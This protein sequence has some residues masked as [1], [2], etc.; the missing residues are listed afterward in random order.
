M[1]VT[2]APCGAYVVGLGS[3]LTLTR[4]QVVRAVRH[5]LVARGLRRYDATATEDAPADQLIG[6]SASLLGVRNDDGLRVEDAVLGVLLAVAEANADFAL[7][8]ARRRDAGA[9]LGRVRITAVELIERY[10]DRAVAAGAAVRTAAAVAGL[11]ASFQDLGHT[12]VERSA[13]ALPAANALLEPDNGWR[14]FLITEQRSGPPDGAPNSVM[15]IDIALIG[16]DARADRVIHRVDRLSI[17][18]LLARI[19]GNR[20]NTPALVALRNRLIPNAM[21]QQF[22]TSGAVQL[23]L[24]EATANLPW[25]LLVDP[26]TPSRDLPGG[27]TAS[28][29]R[30]F[31]E[32][33]DRRFQPVRADAG[34]ALVVAAGQ[35]PGLDPLQGV[36]KEA[37]QLARLLTAHG[38]LKVLSDQGDPAGIDIAELNIALSQSSQILHIASHGRSVD[39]DPLSTGALLAPGFVLNVDVVR[40]MP[41]VPDLV[42]LNC[43]DTG[44]IGPSRWAAGLAREFMAAGA[45]AVVAAGWPVNDTAAFAFAASFYEQ[46]L[47]GKTFGDAVAVARG[48]ARRAGGAATWAAYQCYGDPTLVLR[49]RAASASGAVEPIGQAD[50]IAR[51]ESLR[52]WATDQ[53]DGDPSSLARRRDN[54]LAEWESLR[55]FVEERKVTAFEAEVMRQL[56]LVARELGAYGLAADRYQRFATLPAGGGPAV[57]AN[58]AATVKDLREAANCRVRDLQDGVRRGRRLPAA[59]PSVAEQLAVAEALALGAVA[60]DAGDESQAVL[61]GLYK[62]AATLDTSRRDELLGKAVERYRRF[63]SAAAHPHHREN[64]IQV[65]AVVDLAHARTLDGRSRD[66]AIPETVP[67]DAGARLIDQGLPAPAGFWERVRP[68]NRA[69]TT[70]MVSAPG[71]VQD[72]AVEALVECYGCEFKTR[73]SFAE[74]ASALDHLQDLVDL[75][76]PADDRR[77]ALEGAL[78]KLQDWRPTDPAAESNGPTRVRLETDLHIDA[79]E[80][81]RILHLPEDAGAASRHQGEVVLRALPAGPGDC[82]IIDYPGDDRHHRLLIDGGIGTSYSNGLGAELAAT[83][84]AIDA[85]IVTHVD[86]DHIE[87]V[88]RAARAGLLGRD[89]WFNGRTEI[90]ATLEGAARS[91]TQGDQLSDTLPLS[92]RNRVTNGHAIVAGDSDRTLL[93][94]PGG[95]VATILS[96]TEDGLQR[97]LD[98]WPTSRGAEDQLQGLAE[99]IARFVAEI[100]GSDDTRADHKMGT[101]PSVTNGS[102]I[103]LLLEV[104]G[105]RLLLTGD[106]HADVLERSLA[107]LCAERQERR[108]RVD[109]FKA[110]HHGSRQNISAAMLNLIDPTFVLVCTDGSRHDHPHADALVAMQTAFPN[111]TFVFSDD[112]DQIRARIAEANLTNVIVAQPITLPGEAAA[113]AGRH[114]P[115]GAAIA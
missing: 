106:A 24:D 77:A 91:T 41:Q 45:R 54:L 25:E 35:V 18:A 21:R 87:G 105:A 53:V 104:A 72:A 8:E 40:S 14:R 65:L 32:T 67:S 83:D 15:T 112:T 76:P 70:I 42:F 49:T 51:L 92:R 48:A 26:D 58:G 34:S 3:T 109:V 75:L 6:V 61:A 82:L 95:A 43:C 59:G 102:S 114:V 64:A 68:G 96:P 71:D 79:D 16:R 111:A 33:G 84:A 22:L 98:K 90:V 110:P 27:G 13:G 93:P 36:Y 23:V 115:A 80:Q 37:E 69:L 46:L 4:Q 5:A 9:Q 2:A 99:D 78:D 55:A 12:T 56:A 52:T 86:A 73:S 74:R 19:A 100:D 57:L 10:A 66:G 113:V 88:L 62:K 31:S 89:V 38:E 94:L 7:F 20:G 29:L 107:R 50:L 11:P 17:D 81:I 28:V 30:L 60:L 108:L 101:D 103:A 97:L 1:A 39:G 44:R 85:A 47:A 63:Q